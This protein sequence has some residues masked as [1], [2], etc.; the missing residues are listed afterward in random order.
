MHPTV[1]LYIFI[2]SIHTV[3][4]APASLPGDLPQAG[5]HPM[6][7][8][9]DIERYLIDEE[10]IPDMWLDDLNHVDEEIQPISTP[11]TIKNVAPTSANIR[12][13]SSQTECVAWVPTK[14][15]D[16]YCNECKSDTKAAHDT[17]GC[18]LQLCLTGCRD[19]FCYGCNRWTKEEYAMIWVAL[20]FLIVWYFIRGPY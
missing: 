18:T 13:E 8:N 20:V 15:T 2:L 19:A 1:P 5:S 3:S 11:V 16:Q 10:E 4:C 17:K 6:V 7:T 9:Q 12:D 14:V